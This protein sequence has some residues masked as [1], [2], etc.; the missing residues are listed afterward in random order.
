M[1]WLTVDRH[2]DVPR[3]RNYLAYNGTCERIYARRLKCY[4]ATR[5]WFLLIEGPINRR[6]TFTILFA[7]MHCNRDNTVVF[8]KRDLASGIITSVRDWKCRVS[9]YHFDVPLRTFIIPSHLRWVLCCVE[10]KTQ[11]FCCSAPSRDIVYQSDEEFAA[12]RSAY[13]NPFAEGRKKRVAFLVLQFQS[14]RKT[15]LAE[16]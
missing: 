15:F 7:T 8:S 11:A 9:M 3:N 4:L 16:A 13:Q 1:P 10:V 12:R 5:T 6:P 2:N 14:P